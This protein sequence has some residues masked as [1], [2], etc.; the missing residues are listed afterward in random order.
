VVDEALASKICVVISVIF[1]GVLRIVGKE[2]HRR[3]PTPP[4]VRYYVLEE[5]SRRIQSFR[6]SVC[7]NEQNIR[8]GDGTLIG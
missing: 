5:A 8:R 3:G 6:T 1:L 2:D 4:M 7:Y